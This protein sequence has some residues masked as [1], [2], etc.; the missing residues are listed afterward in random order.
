M[1]F[2]CSILVWF[3][4]GTSTCV[5]SLINSV[6]GTGLIGD[7]SLLLDRSISRGTSSLQ[8]A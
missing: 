2:L 6:V 4:V 7:L 8:G 1:L 5:S 3:C